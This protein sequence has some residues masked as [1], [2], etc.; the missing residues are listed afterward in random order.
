ML[1]LFLFILVCACLIA[2]S[3]HQH[4]LI[5]ILVIGFIQD[6]FRKLVPGEPIYFIVTV[7]IVFG[8]LLCKTVNRVGIN[9]IKIPFIYWMDL[10]RKPISLFLI[11]LAIQF[12]HSL[13]RWGNVFVSLI[14][15]L[16][17]IAPFLA[18][19]VGYYAI[20]N[21]SEVRRFMKVYVLFGLVLAISVALSFAGYDLSI[22]REIGVGLK[23]YDQGT[24]LRSFSGFMRTGEIAAWH[25]AT[26]ICFII[27]LYSTSERKPSILVTLLLIAFLLFVM[28]FT[29]RRKMLMLVTLF[30][31]FFVFAFFYYQKTLSLVSVV[32]SCT[33][34]VCLWAIYEYFFS[35]GYS[36]DVQYYL[37]RSSSV[38]SNATTRFWELGINP[39]KWA[40]NRVGL[41]GGGLGIASQ[42]AH[43]FQSNSVAGGSGE[44]GFGK[45]MVELGLP[46]LL[47][48][49]W[50][51]FSMIR[52]ILRCLNL[53][54]QHF[55]DSKLLVLVL[56]VSVF[57]I[58]NAMTFS[59]ATQLYGDF[60][61]LIL[62]GLVSGFVFSLP[63]LVVIDLEQGKHNNVST[64]VKKRFRT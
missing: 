31:A 64:N 20:N 43:F 29:G 44:G 28:T 8:L 40:Y 56:G 59:V 25:L 16:S 33:L 58:V 49:I 13:L 15:L 11:I 5:A 63:K 37:A 18:I 9:G 61:V 41:L 1:L 45:V 3:S 53:A 36:D 62:L 21:I 22:F 55:V 51:A 7:G 10:L 19:I 23:I 14:G 34:V 26:T 6:P 30:G 12:F 48:L 57:L 47:I 35:G 4:A 32:F 54:S 50:L 38:Y 52:Y 60:F 2:V 46:G 27:I 39:L 42:G 24:V 17:Y